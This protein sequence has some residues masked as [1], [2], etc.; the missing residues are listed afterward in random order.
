MDLCNQSCLQVGWLSHMVKTLLNIIH[1]LFN[2]IFSY[3]LLIGTIDLKYFRP[4]SVTMT[5]AV[6][7]KAIGKQNGLNLLASVS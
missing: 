2:H 5:L 6:D 3:R 1:K 7:H 4:L